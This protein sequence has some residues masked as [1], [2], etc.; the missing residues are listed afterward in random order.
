MLD[1]LTANFSNILK[2][3]RGQ[4]RLTETNIQDMLQKIQQS[5]LE[6]DV[7]VSVIEKFIS[8]IKIRV[9][10]ERVL[11]GLTPSQMLV[12]IVHKE[13]VLLLG[14][15][16]QALNLA[17][18][19]PAILLIAGLQ[20][21]GKTTTAGK[22]GALLKKQKKKVLLASVDM[23]RPAAI[24]QLKLLAEQAE[25]AY[26]ES[27]VTQ[28]PLSNA[29]AAKN[30]AKRYF[31][32]VLILD[33]AGRVAIDQIMM[34]EIK[35]IHAL[36]KPIET[37]FVV[38]AMQG[39]DA[40][41]TAHAFGD[42]LPLT[43]LIITKLDSDA[44]GGAALSARQITGQPIKFIGISEK[45]DGLS[46]F[47]PERLAN[48]ILGLGDMLSL[49]EDIK[50]GTNT[51]Q[52]ATIAKKIQRGKNFNLEDFKQHMQQIQ[53][54][55]G[56]TSL[57]DKMPSHFAQPISE[58]QKKEADKKIHR[59]EAIINSMT[60]QERQEP[61]IIKSSRKRRIAAG[62]GVTVQA[63]NQLLEQFEQMQ[64]MMKQFSKGGL[65]K[66][67]QGLQNRFAKQIPI[68]R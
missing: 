11:E 3:I 29:E 24:E 52:A 22:L 47:Y 63:V 37:L 31:F 50:K 54:M 62:A 10:D 64:K 60:I 61:D 59:H 5:F 38:D 15:Q 34:E 53:A 18:I 14:Q 43:G 66:L 67:M 23:Y 49:I 7:A 20:G 8:H 51:Q 19:P 27:D 6:A 30:Y 48:R 17:T 36:V 41:N 65:G 1:N 55:G 25:V 56:T 32:D 28:T 4:A 40:A 45:I 26:F 9:T 57:L 68:Q 12:D 39:Q 21:T 33:T 13:L 35:A 16:H 2:N 46:I 58:L 44:R 42:A